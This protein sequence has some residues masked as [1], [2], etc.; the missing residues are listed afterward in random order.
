MDISFNS[1]RRN[2]LIEITIKYGIVKKKKKSTKS[3]T[4]A[5]TMLRLG[6]VRDLT[7]LIGSK[8]LQWRIP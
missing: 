7:L 5:V 4:S 3:G 6:V 2:F 1:K 8:G